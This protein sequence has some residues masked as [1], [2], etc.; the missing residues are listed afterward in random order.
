[1]GSAGTPFALSVAP[2]TSA[3]AFYHNLLTLL[4]SIGKVSGTIGWPETPVIV[5]DPGE[6]LHHSVQEDGL[7][8]FKSEV[9]RDIRQRID[10]CL[11]TFC[12]AILQAVLC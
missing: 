4:K 11:N 10:Q 8:V 12:L 5:N 1:M 6:P 2:P 7:D 3:G 9:T